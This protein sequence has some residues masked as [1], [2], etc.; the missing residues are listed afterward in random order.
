MRSDVRRWV[1]G[2]AMVGAALS[3]PGVS[4][5]T[6]ICTVISVLPYTISAQGSYCLDRN[7]S[8]AMTTGAAITINTDFVVLDLNGFKV[9]GGSGGP[10]TQTSGVF[11]QNHKNIT[12]KNGNIRGFLRGVYLKDTSGTFTSSQGHL[13][14][15]VRA[16]QNTFAGIVVEGRGNVVRN[17]QVVDTTG[18]TVNGANSDAIGLVVNGPG[19]RVINNDSTETVAVGTGT[20]YGIQIS[21]ADGAVVEN[22]RVGNSV[23]V[24][25]STAISLASGDDVLV[26]GNRMATM[27]L[28]VVFAAAN[29]KY[30]DNITSGVTTAYTGGT[31]AGN[32][33]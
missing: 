15:D 18:T 33:Q 3:A 5:E 21:A 29:G 17:N 26:V 31:D 25:G 9:G 13:V 27:G 16:D 20:A 2:T 24:S 1:L 6:T 19:S 22:N 4:A 32:N 14:E 10:G 30:R 12:V 11:A 8:T 28:G 23:L 7:L